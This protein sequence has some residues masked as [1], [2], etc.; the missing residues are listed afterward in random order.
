M[1]RRNVKKE[2]PS[3]SS[4]LAEYP[5]VLGLSLEGNIQPTLSF[6]NKTGF[7]MLYSD[8]KP[9][10]SSTRPS[11]NQIQ[12]KGK[13]D[14]NAQIPFIR[15]QNLA[16]SLFQRLLPR[17]HFFLA[18]KEQFMN[19]TKGAHDHSHF[20]YIKKPSLHMLSVADDWRYWEELGVDVEEYK[21][22]KEDS[23]P[24]L[25]FSSQ[26]DTWLKTGRPIDV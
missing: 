24:R 7:I 14:T 3:L 6:Y 26:F 20:D 10:D 16:S 18:N 23:I 15:G 11:T 25:K 19:K 17:W 13:D 9:M 1:Q 5:S 12:K 4:L 2:K 22:F 21:L 8:W